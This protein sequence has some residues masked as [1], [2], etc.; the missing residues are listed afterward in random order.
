MAYHKAYWAEELEG[1]WAKIDRLMSK[2]A[3]EKKIVDFVFTHGISQ[4]KVARS[5]ASRYKLRLEDAAFIV[6]DVVEREYD[7][8]DS[9][10]ALTK[11]L[12]G[13]R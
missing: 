7:R 3:V 6:D 10:Y 9:E 5:L 1:Y 11:G 12:P 4:A 8:Q 13:G 2:G